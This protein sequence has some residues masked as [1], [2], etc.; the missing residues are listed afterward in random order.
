MQTP[1]E[2]LRLCEVIWVWQKFSIHSMNLDYPWKISGDQR[3]SPL[4][5]CLEIGT[6]RLLEDRFM[7]FHHM[8]CFSFAVPWPVC[9]LRSFWFRVYYWALSSQSLLCWQW[10]GFFRES[11]STNPSEILVRVACLE[12][13][14]SKFCTSASL[15]MYIFMCIERQCFSGEGFLWLP[16][17]SELLALKWAG[18]NLR[19]Y[20][21]NAS[22]C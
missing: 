21:V 14:I 9:V 22:L 15:R 10:Y 2:Y 3:S 16:C 1:C 12:N 19:P 5:G 7:C 17:F 11:G 20:Q 18:W 8:P 6:S 4:G 13:S